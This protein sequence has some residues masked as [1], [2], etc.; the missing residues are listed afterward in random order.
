MKERKRQGHRKVFSL[1]GG[2]KAT[3]KAGWPMKS[4]T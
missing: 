2:Y 3:V 4:G 1:T